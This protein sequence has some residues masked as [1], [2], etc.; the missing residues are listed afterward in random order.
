MVPGWRQLR[1]NSWL[2]ATEKAARAGDILCVC[3]E[4]LCRW[5]CSLRLRLREQYLYSWLGEVFGQAP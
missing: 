1:S 3:Q 4:W 2:G 5:H